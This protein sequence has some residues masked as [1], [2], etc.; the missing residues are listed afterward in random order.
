MSIDSKA[1]EHESSKYSH[2][3]TIRRFGVRV[4]CHR[5]HKHRLV[6]VIDKLDKSSFKKAVTSHHTPKFIL[7]APVCA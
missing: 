5:F 4:T 3:I 6:D 1:P 2:P 7:F